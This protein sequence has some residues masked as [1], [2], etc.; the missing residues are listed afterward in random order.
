M[1]SYISAVVNEFFMSPPMSQQPP[2][3]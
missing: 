2:V 3:S 1:N